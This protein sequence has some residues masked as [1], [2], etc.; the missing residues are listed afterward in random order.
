MAHY[1]C[2]DCGDHMGIAYGC[3]K[4][5][6][7]KEVLKLKEQLTEETAT[8]GKR[9][10][11]LQAERREAYVAAMTEDIRL[12]HEFA[13]EEHMPERRRRIRDQIG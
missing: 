3:C 11:D 13:Y 5:C 7:P 8:A 10:D 4:G 12:Q 6:T 1:D 2:R 9:F